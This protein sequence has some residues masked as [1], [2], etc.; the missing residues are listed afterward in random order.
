MHFA[1]DRDALAANLELLEGLL[2]TLTGVLDIRGVF[3][4][5]SA[6]AGKVL[7]HDAMSLPILTEDREHVI[8]LATAGLPAGALPPVQ[9]VDDVM[10]WLMAEPWDWHTLDDLQAPTAPE[11]MA[12][13]LIGGYE[14]YVQLGYR[15]LLRVPIRLDGQLAGLLGF[16]S[17]R[18]AAFSRPDALVARRIADHVALALSHQR[19][20][21]ERGRAEAL[22][23][24]TASLA[25]LDGL[26]ATLTEVL[27]VRQVFDR[28]SDVLQEVLP[29]DLLGYHEINE[30][31][32]RIRVRAASRGAGI[33]LDF[34]APVPDPELFKK[35]W[36]YQIVDDLPGHPVH[37]NTVAVQ[38]GMKSALSV[39]I[40][41][42][43]RLQAAVVL[44]SVRVRADLLLV[45]GDPTSRISD[46]SNVVAV[47]KAGVRCDREAHRAALDEEKDAVRALRHAPPPKGSE[48]GLVSD[49]EDGT[50][51]ARF[52]L[53]WKASAGRMLGGRQPRAQIDVVDGGAEGSRKA[54]RVTGEIAEGVFGWAGALF[55]PG[56]APM[57]PVNLSA[58]TAISFWTRG[59]GRTYEVLLNAKS[60]GLLPAARSFV[61]GP[62][63]RQVTIPLAEF[64]TDAADLQGL[65]F[66]ALA[67][68]GP[69]RVSIDSVRFER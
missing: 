38:A 56:A 1:P 15:S 68:P 64:G 51:T 67:S 44:R 31:G 33:P 62:E 32:D 39:G 59:D 30:A 23:E 60:K 54:L 12:H 2:T 58:K 9:P 29:H 11:D 18:V 6:I 40:R 3:E 61:A 27:D 46:V 5:V 42:G 34:E 65:R 45:D 48:S 19:L 55:F 22:R 53:G 63:W 26:L 35:Q 50:A 41:F 20:A 57:A 69:F 43:G 25:A 13:R 16:F 4:R 52:G 24:R 17:R 7:A 66:A 49:F 8:P 47:W 37:G 14:A 21:E 28:I 36:E 10:R